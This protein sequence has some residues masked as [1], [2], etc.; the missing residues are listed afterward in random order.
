MTSV[1][2]CEKR[3]VILGMSGH[4]KVVIEVARAMGC[5]TQ[6]LCLDDN[7]S[8]DTILTV[9]VVGKIASFVQYVGPHT[10]FI[11]A[12]GNNEIRE[13]FTIDIE[14]AGGTLATLID[15]NAVVSSTS[16]VGAGSLIMPGSIVNA[17][18]QIGRSCIINTGA[19]VDHD[20]HVEDFV[21]IAPGTNLAGQVS[22]GRCT[23]IGIGSCVIQCCEIG[24]HTMIGAGATVVN[25]IPS[26]VTAVGSPAKVIKNNKNTRG[27]S[28]A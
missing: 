10:E 20:C 13:K 1:N 22:V 27:D 15:P 2:S 17:C 11:V 25:P 7:P 3:L 26:Y 19:T 14:N 23:M 9:P 6:M 24:S 28:H 8:A 4:G 21:H 18:A 5:Y 12:I 16:S